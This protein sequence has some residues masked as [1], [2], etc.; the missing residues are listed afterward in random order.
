M[1]AVRDIAVRRATR[2]RHACAAAA[3]VA[4]VALVALGTGDGAVAETLSATLRP[5]K[6]QQIRDLGAMAVSSP[7]YGAPASVRRGHYPFNHTIVLKCFQSPP[8]IHSI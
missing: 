7:V 5:G 3:A 6:A 1:V 8:N 2:R 4:V